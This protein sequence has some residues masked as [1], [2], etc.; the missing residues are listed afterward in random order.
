LLQLAVLFLQFLLS[1]GL[2]HLQSS[3]LLAPVAERLGLSAATGWGVGF[4]LLML[5]QFGHNIVT[6]CSGV[7]LWMAMT[8]FSSKWIFSHTTQISPVRSERIKRAKL[9]VCH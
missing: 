7:Y 3:I 8:G 5:L 6:I 2:V 4:P 1:L 9:Y